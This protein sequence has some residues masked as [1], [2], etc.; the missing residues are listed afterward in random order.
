MARRSMAAPGSSAAVADASTQ[1]IAAQTRDLRL[2]HPEVGGA[3]A[4]VSSRAVG[5]G[6]LGPCAHL[7]RSVAT[8]RQRTGPQLR[9]WLK[10]PARFAHAAIELE[11]EQGLFS[12]L[13]FRA[14]RHSEL[15][16]VT[17]PAARYRLRELEATLVELELELPTALR[18][19]FVA[20]LGDDAPALARLTPRVRSLA[21]CDSIGSSSL[22]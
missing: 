7:P 20:F 5:G 8:C 21:C 14:G 15:E 4:D 10:A 17:A 16:L 18:L 3:A 11:L 22:T 2:V 9:F 12:L 19:F 6:H 1:A 13:C